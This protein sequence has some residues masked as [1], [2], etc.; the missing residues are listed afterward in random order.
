MDRGINPLTSQKSPKT[1]LQNHNRFA[2]LQFTANN[3]QLDGSPS[4]EDVDENGNRLRLKLVPG[5]KT[6]SQ[7]TTVGEET[8]VFS[9]S[10]S[11]GIRVGEFNDWFNGEGRVSFRRFHGGKA[12]HFRHYMQP[13][14]EEV[15]PKTVI[16]QCGGNDLPTP[17]GE[18]AIPVEQIAEDVISLGEFSR[19]HGVK[20]ILIAGVPIRKRQ[21][22]QERCKQLNNILMEFCK[23]RGYT[24]VDNSNIEVTHVQNDGTHLTYEGSDLLANNYL[25][26]LND[27]ADWERVTSAQS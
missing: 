4:E 18:T 12:R 20:N 22:I 17:K 8:L 11:K 5:P 7:V 19:Q 27:L 3:P 15:A 26:Y 23:A 6:Y 9:T 2:S 25:Y 24:Y 21:Y 1:T 16:I 14:L 13:H 10:I